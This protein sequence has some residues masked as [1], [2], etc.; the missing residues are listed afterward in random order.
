MFPFSGSSLRMKSSR[1]IF[2]SGSVR[3]GSWCQTRR[4]YVI[5]EDLLSWST[6]S[7]I[8]V[9]FHRFES[10]RCD[11]GGPFAEQYIVHTSVEELLAEFPSAT[12]IPS[13][14]ELCMITMF[15]PLFAFTNHGTQTSKNRNP[16]S[17]SQRLICESAKQCTFPF[18]LR[19]L[20]LIFV[21][22]Q[23]VSLLSA[24]ILSAH[25]AL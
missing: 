20:R 22:Q 5:W 12:T 14:K 17:H 2:V 3:V 8:E 6:V 9:Y 16:E 23:Y 19:L 24:S 13:L 1:K 18:S 21:S 11:I 4:H 25:V 15:I 7:F 10:H